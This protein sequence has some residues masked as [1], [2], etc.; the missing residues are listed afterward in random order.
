MSVSP[1]ALVHLLGGDGQW[2]RA[3]ALLDSGSE[4]NLMTKAFAKE[5]KLTYNPMTGGIRGIGGNIATQV[6]GFVSTNLKQCPPFSQ[7]KVPFRVVTKTVPDAPSS[8]FPVSDWE[9]LAD[10]PLADPTFNEPSPVDVVFSASVFDALDLS[11]M[12]RS[13]NGSPNARLTTCYHVT[14]FP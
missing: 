2:Y 5:S 4:I 9:H 7:L 11:Q 6:V 1:T 13:Q 12:I 3:R 14:A 8:Y 10:R